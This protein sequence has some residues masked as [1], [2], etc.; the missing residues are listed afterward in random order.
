MFHSSIT[1]AER[2]G[3]KLMKLCGVGLS[4]DEFAEKMGQKDGKPTGLYMTIPH[5]VLDALG[6]T[7]PAVTEH[8]EPVLWDAPIWC[9]L[10]GRDIPPGEAAGIRMVAIAKTQ[11]GITA[12]AEIELR[13]FREGQVENMTWRIDGRPGMRLVFERDD[14][15]HFSAASL[16]N[17]IPDVIAAPPG[18]QPVRTL[19]PMRH[20]ALVV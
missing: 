9:R 19:G 10:L 15:V 6:Y 4:Q 1:D 7:V 2:I 20:S 18:I 12:R 3:L 11:E 8:R 17:R 5:Q 14:S 13:V 16:F